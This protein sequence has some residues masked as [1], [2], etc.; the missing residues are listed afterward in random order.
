MSRNVARP[1]ARARR[2][3]RNALLW[4]GLSALAIILLLYFEQIAL[5]YVLA[6]LSVAALLMIVAFADLGGARQASSEPAPRDDSA[7]IGDGTT[8][9]TSFG[10]A[11]GRQRR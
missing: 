3:G 10:T 7:A 11:A 1:T 9:A 2:K 5:L 6:T 4:V 8:V